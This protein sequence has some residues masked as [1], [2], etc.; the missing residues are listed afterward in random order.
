MLCVRH[1]NDTPRL[2]WQNR[3]YTNLLFHVAICNL[4]PEA[5]MAAIPF[6]LLLVHF[7]AD[8][9]LWSVVCEALVVVRLSLV[10]EEIFAANEIGRAK[11]LLFLPM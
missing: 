9:R 6:I 5:T 2:L 10:D 4:R 1:D 11:I 7:W 8:N 3:E